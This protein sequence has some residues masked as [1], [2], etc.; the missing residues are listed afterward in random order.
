ML[1]C[2][3]TRK[4]EPLIQS[5][6]HRERTELVSH[7]NDQ[8]KT[9]KNIDFPRDWKGANSRIYNSE[10]IQVAGGLHIVFCTQIIP[11]LSLAKVITMSQCN[12]LKMDS[13]GFKISNF[14]RMIAQPPGLSIRSIS[15]TITMGCLHLYQSESH[16]SQ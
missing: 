16:S 3:S 4:N 12:V 15:T 5:Y 2:T 9:E 1:L 14:S 13:R 11:S 8:I 6:I 7:V 10:I